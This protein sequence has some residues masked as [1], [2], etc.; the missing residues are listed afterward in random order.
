MMTIV[1]LRILS[2]DITIALK[3][4]QN[5]FSS[6]SKKSKFEHVFQSPLSVAKIYIISF[7]HHVKQLHITPLF[8]GNEFFTQVGVREHDLASN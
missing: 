1:C 4:L 2:P 7:C 3:V 6:S 5:V 8:H